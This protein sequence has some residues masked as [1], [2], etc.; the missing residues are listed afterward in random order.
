MYHGYVCTSIDVCNIQDL[1]RQ[2]DRLCQLTRRY[3][4]AEMFGDRIPT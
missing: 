1:R 3:L 4:G 2:Q